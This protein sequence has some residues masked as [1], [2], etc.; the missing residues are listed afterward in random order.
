MILLLALVVGFLS[1][2]GV[3]LMAFLTFGQFS[4]DSGISPLLLGMITFFSLT[5]TNAIYIW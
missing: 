3:I 5:C 4:L 2:V 1:S